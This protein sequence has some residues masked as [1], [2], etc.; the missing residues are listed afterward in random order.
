MFAKNLNKQFAD[1]HKFSNQYI[2]ESILLLQK[3]RKKMEK[4]NP[5]SLTEQADFYSHI[6]MEDISGGDH[7]HA[8]RL[9]QRL[10]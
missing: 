2:N 3:A 5:A 4:F 1:T 10:K 9:L 7:T 8:E 6:T